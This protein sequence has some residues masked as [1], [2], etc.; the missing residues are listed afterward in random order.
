MSG[1]FGSPAFMDLL[2]LSFFSQESP[3]GERVCHKKSSSKS[4]G[5]VSKKLIPV[6]QNIELEDR[7]SVEAFPGTTL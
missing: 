7:R 1:V 6:K 2:L 3:C 5:K 4:K